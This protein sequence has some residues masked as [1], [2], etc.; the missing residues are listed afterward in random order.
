MFCV[1]LSS[2]LRPPSGQRLAGCEHHCCKGGD[3]PRG[4]D[5]EQL[6]ISSL[7]TRTRLINAGADAQLTSIV[8]FSFSH[9][10]T[11]REYAFRTCH[12]VKQMCLY[13]ILNSY[14]HL[15]QLNMEKF[16]TEMKSLNSKWS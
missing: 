10:D 15:K 5:C 4:G 16:A 3:C 1:F 11:I 6:M 7:L 12:L 14:L 13:L 8:L 2:S 9:P